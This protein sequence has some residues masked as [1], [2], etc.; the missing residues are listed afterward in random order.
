V[1]TGQVVSGDL[2]PVDLLQWLMVVRHAQPELPLVWLADPAT[3]EA[4]SEPILQGELR[5]SG[6]TVAAV[7][8]SHTKWSLLSQA[9][10]VVS[11]PGHELVD[12]AQA[13]GIPSV[14][15]HLHADRRAEWTVSGVVQVGP[16][17]T[18]FLTAVRA[19]LRGPRDV[20]DPSALSD[21]GVRDLIAQLRHWL[22]DRDALPFRLHAHTAAA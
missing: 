2:A 5:Q 14:V 9:R 19:A 1:V 16:S 3:A 18:Q 6:I 22:K 8:G 12:E 4:L 21:L 15:V 11:G 20:R 10:C 17:Q 13:L 7:Q